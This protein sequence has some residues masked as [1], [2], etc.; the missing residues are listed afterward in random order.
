MTAKKM[1]PGNVLR[2]GSLVVIFLSMAFLIADFLGGK[3]LSDTKEKTPFSGDVDMVDWGFSSGL[4]AFIVLLEN[5]VSSAV[6]VVDVEIAGIDGTE[7]NEGKSISIPAGR[8]DTDFRSISGVTLKKNQQYDF[9][10]KIIYRMN[11][12]QDNLTSVGNLHG[13]YIPGRGADN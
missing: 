11:V 10:I 5:K 13:A 1:F 7:W 4:G 6:E 8:R 9:E 3:P 2:Y 12:T